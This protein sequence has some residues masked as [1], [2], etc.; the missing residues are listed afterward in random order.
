LPEA[1][2]WKGL[3]S[4]GMIESERFINCQMT[5]ERQHYLCS[6][7]NVKSFAHAGRAFREDDS[8]IRKGYAPENFNIVH[9]LAINLLKKEP[10]KLSIK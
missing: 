5:L 4:I 2:K 6:L 3:K 10:S 1:K 7:T 9:Q 8:R